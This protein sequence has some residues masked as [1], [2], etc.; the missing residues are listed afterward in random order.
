MCNNNNNDNNYYYIKLVKSFQK[1]KEDRNLKL[2]F[3]DARRYAE[4]L[5]L[6]CQFN[7]EATVISHADQVAVISTK[8]GG[9]T[10]WFGQIEIGLYYDFVKPPPNFFK[11]LVPPF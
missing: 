11:L 3:K 1:K 10:I 9:L 8:R 2:V 5:Q 4:E 7:E 6:D